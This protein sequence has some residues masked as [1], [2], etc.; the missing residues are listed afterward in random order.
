MSSQRTKRNYPDNQSLPHP[1]KDREQMQ[2]TVSRREFLKILGGGILISISSESIFSIQERGRQS[3]RG[4]PLDFNTYL[5]IAQDGQVS[6]FT[7]KIEMGQGIHTSFAQMLAEELEVP[8][9][10]VKMVMG[11]TDLCPWDMGTFGSRSTKYFGPVLRQAAA[12]AREVL[13]QLASERLNLPL[14]RLKAKNGF[15]LEKNNPENKVSYATLT[16]GKKIEKSLEGKPPLKPLSDYE[17]CGEPFE[18][19]DGWE[20]V[21]GR[22]E[23]AGDIRLPNM[24]YARI[25][26]PPAHRAQLKSVD[27]SAAQAVKDAR[28]VQDGDLIAVL[29]PTPD[30]AERAL[31]KIKAQYDVPDEQLDNQTIFEHLVKAAPEG[32]LVDQKGDLEKG[33]SLALVNFE[34]TYLNKY[35]A[36]AP[37]EPHTALAKVEGDQA[38]LWVSTQRP[39]GDKDTVAQTLGIPAENVRVITPFVGGGFGGKTRNQQAVEAA[40]LSKLAGQPVQVAWTRKEE[41]FYDTF[42]P[43]AVIKIK[44]GLDKQGRIIFWDYM[45]FHA[46]E[47]TSHV[48]YDIPHHRVFMRGG[49]GRGA[50]DAHPFRV[51]AWRGPGS[52]TNTYARESHID[53][54]AA[55][56]GID[57]LEFRLRHL[58]GN[59]RMKRVLEAAAEKFN[60][61]FEKA[62]SGRGFGISCVDYLNTYVATMAE[63]EVNKGT[64]EIRVTRVVCAQDMGEVINPE[65]ARIQIDSCVT[66]GLGYTLS[67]EIHFKG[68]QVLDTNFDTYEIPRFSWVP[69]I[70]AVLV[71]NSDLAP[72]GCGEPA[73][74]NMGSVIANAVFDALGVR[75]FELPMNPERVR[76]AIERAA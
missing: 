59:P 63:V 75:M 6:C 15:V 76:K 22:A 45:I 17:I 68:G 44:S 3:G 13:L 61:K 49:W 74:T 1:A 66:M 50:S 41:F 55:K 64:G 60:R 18:R 70:E 71:R 27:V 23:F 47:R 54:M 19:L 42:Q 52:N 40:R 32:N 2:A 43:A 26:R 14:N 51:G 9:G 8:L 31:E 69:K 28:V 72:Q 53:M 33:R 73:I 37:L 21:T 12:E 58:E 57:P 16:E 62:P 46:G 34:A 10:S 11:D 36:H 7:G 48:F 4:E 25:L 38:T 24:L 29:H 65:G 5:H 20:K 67:E 39:F 30:G 35:V 56:V